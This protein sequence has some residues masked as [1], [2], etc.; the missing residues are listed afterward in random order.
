MCSLCQTHSSGNGQ[1][2]DFLEMSSSGVEIVLYS[3][4]IC[5][6]LLEPY[7]ATSRFVLLF[8]GSSN[9]PHCLPIHTFKGFPI[10]SYVKSLL[11]AKPCSRSHGMWRDAASSSKRG[12]C[13]AIFAE[14]MK[15]P[16]Y[17]HPFHG[18][19]HLRLVGLGGDALGAAIPM[20]RVSAWKNAIGG[21]V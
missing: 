4:V 18:D 17:V 21:H 10:R 16:K 13:V 7:D 8:M 14:H 19:V 12:V 6:T 20:S 11:P 9:F 3:V 1:T 5:C 15:S 2:N